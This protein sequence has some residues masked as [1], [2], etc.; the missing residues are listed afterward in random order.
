VKKIS[1]IIPTY[2]RQSEILRAV[3]SVIQQTVKPFEIIVIDDGSTDN[4]KNTLYP[5][6]EYIRYIKTENNG[7]SSARNRGILESKGDWVGFL[8]SDDTWLPQKLQYQ[9]DVISKS[10]SLVCFC[11]SADEKGRQLDGLNI[12]DPSLKHGNHQDYPPGDCRFFI[13]QKH[14]MLPSLLVEKKALMKAGLFD[15]LLKVAED[16]KLI[17]RLTLENGFSVINKN[18]VSV[19]RERNTPGLSDTQDIKN[20]Y[21]RYNCYIQ[22]QAEAYWKV[23][24]TSKLAAK[25][26]RK[27]TLYFISRQAEVACALGKRD[28]AKRYAQAGISFHSNWRSNCRNFFILFAYSKAKRYYSKKWNHSLESVPT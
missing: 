28:L 10:K 13:H 19:C 12:I 23:F 20:A 18:L 16:T 5:V 27:S 6:K 17:Y 24:R 26:I 4:T 1:V 15:E 8:D 7:V 11:G 2:N 21:I 22:V 14:L 9:L 25:I 3:E